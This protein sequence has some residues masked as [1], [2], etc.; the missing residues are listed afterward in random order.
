METIKVLLFA[1]N[2]Q[3]TAPLDLAREFREIDEEVRMGPFRSAVELILVPGARPVDLLRK[4][5]ENR[6]QVIHFSS[7]GDPDAIVLESGD[8]QVLAVSPMRSPDER[9][10]K[11]VRPGGGDTSST[12]Q[13][14]PHGVSKSALVNVLRACDEGDLRLVVLN[15]CH[16]R[17][18][19]E[20][21]TEVVDCVVSMNRTI[22]DRAAIKF[23]ASFY[24]ALAFGKSVQKA[25]EQGVA[26]LSAEGIGETD[27]PELLVRPGVDASGLVLVGPAPR[28]AAKQVPEAPFLV[29]F[30]RNGDF[31]GR[32]SDLARL[33][34]SLSS[35]GKGP[36]GIRPA[37]LTGM[38]GIGKTQLAVEYVH[39]HREDYTDGI[40]WIDAAG[41]LA[42]GFARLAT[43]PRLRWAE[44]DRPCDEQVHSAF[45]ALNDRSRALLVLDNLHDPAVI[46][47]PLVPGCVPEDLRSRLL[48]TTRRHDLGRFA[49]VEVTVLPEEPALRLLLRHPSRRAALDPAHPDHEHARAIARML[50]RLPLALELAG[51][52]LGK[53]SVDVPLAGYRQGLKS[54]GALATLDA[55]AAELNEADLRRVH[56]PA[57][58]TTIREQWEALEYDPARLL[59]RVASLFP[60]SS[61]IPI[62]RLSLLAGLAEEARP[63]RLSPIHRAVKCLDDACLIERLEADQL[64]LHPL[65][66]EFGAAQAS[67]R[68]GDFRRPCLER[69][70]ASLETFS[71]LEALGARR[72]FDAIQEDLI[73]ILEV[74]PPSAPDVSHRLRSLL[75]LV[76][77]EVNHFRGGEPGSH[78]VLF[79]QQV[80]NRAFFEGIGPLQI[81]ADRTLAALGQPHFRLIW[82]ARRESPALVRTF[83]G[84]ED[85]VAAV[86]V[87][88]DGRRVLSGSHDCTLRLWD[89]Q[90]GR[91]LRSFVGHTD[92]VLMVATMPDGRGALSASGDGTIRLWDLETGETRHIVRGDEIPLYK[93][94]V[95]PDGQRAVSSPLSRSLELWDL[96]SGRF[97]F[98]LIGHGDIVRAVAVTP[99]GHRA[100]SGSQDCTLKLWD[101]ANGRLVLT[102][103]GHKA[104]VT[105][106]AVLPDGGRAISGSVDGILEVWDLASGRL[107]LT[108]AGHA[109]AA[110][111]PDGRQD[112][113]RGR[114]ETSAAVRALA[115][116]PDGRRAV[117]GS[118]DR[119]LKLWDLESGQLL[120]TLAGHD[121]LV[122]AVAVTPDGRHAVSASADRT[123]KLWDLAIV[124][125]RHS[126]VGHEAEVSAVAIAPDGRHVLSASHDHSLK[127]WDLK[128]G[129][130]V[131]SFLGHH[132]KVTA[133]AMTADGRHALSGSEDRTL[134]LWDLEDGRWL[135][136]LTGHRNGVSAVA[137]APGG[138]QAVSGSYDRSARLWDLATGQTILSCAVHESGVL[139]VAVTPDGSRV[140][141]GSQGGSLKLWE[142][143]TGQVLIHFVGHGAPINAV[144]VTPD[145]LRAL[146][147]SADRTLRLWHLAT[148]QLL[149][150]FAGHLRAVSAVAVTRDGRHVLSASL[151]R[152]LRL[153]N[154][155]DGD[156]LAMALM[157]SAP[158][159]IALAPD[160]PNVVVGDRV[161]NVHCF[162]VSLK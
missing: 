74:C 29:P 4:L 22:S 36:V 11:S 87:T 7:H 90:T 82:T 158:V 114:G 150:T 25:F 70:V 147:A 38:G 19:A 108:L 102:L 2:P 137:E 97:R 151:D 34:A 116:T 132:D 15:A 122:R 105:A 155:S 152:T 120:L 89:L 119:T 110:P 126:S 94:A 149:H 62:A 8:P 79:V 103:A 64:R 129:Q 14:Q 141:S 40:F 144:V 139:A 135:H 93:V 78:P 33:H 71:T 26:R 9:D 41:P 138:R 107:L 111:V 86:A 20:G 112:A 156:C 153:W 12:S 130:A 13:G 98:N 27:T 6:P 121:H 96:A 1:A 3:G 123:L 63:G 53:Y 157:E 134:M 45:A 39:R 24:G 85:Q 133:L 140:V 69:A 32:D 52:Y 142:L 51:A 28:P 136:C 21:L 31:V 35:S 67:D 68:T 18:Q 128:T 100:L 44:A 95:T 30:P 161:G 80:R 88:V 115:V 81:T 92:G 145:G 113:D 48:F 91:L 146:S 127:L 56:D 160:R 104:P 109:D 47:V 59:L 159:A 117:S 148:G 83:V 162:H 124:Q 37:G 10:M 50:G 42:E 143:A 101:L 46:A 16:T 65:I 5:N 118:G 131:R 125:T 73:A 61:A 43:D 75:R 57:V 23:A 66:R 54:D 17:A 99:D 58:A 154:I 49:G 76:Q 106:V 84:H 60:E 72:G 77:R 55:D